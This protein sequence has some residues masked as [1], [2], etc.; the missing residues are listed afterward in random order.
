MIT[1]HHDKY[2]SYISFSLSFGENCNGLIGVLR[3]KWWKLMNGSFNS[4]APKS[5]LLRSYHCSGQL[6]MCNLL[7]EIISKL[8]FLL[9][10]QIYKK[11]KKDKI[12][13]DNNF[14]RLKPVSFCIKAFF[15]FLES[16][17]KV[18]ID[19]QSSSSH[20]LRS[21]PGKQIIV[22]NASCTCMDQFI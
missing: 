14:H 16:N 13:R 6:S 3:D 22:P 15:F 10:E 12:K 5:N 21:K 11:T 1:K 19:L 20:Y 2:L 9:P 17:R 7:H 4:Q 18:T 8:N